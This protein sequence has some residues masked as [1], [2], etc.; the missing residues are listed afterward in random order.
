MLDQ[1]CVECGD[2]VKMNSGAYRQITGW[3]EIRGQGGA[4]K[5]VGRVTTG[6]VM[7][8]A[9]LTSKRSNPGQGML[10]TGGE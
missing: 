4:N 5:I 7:H 9:C 1:K 10:D 3:E 2:F 6:Q 8:H